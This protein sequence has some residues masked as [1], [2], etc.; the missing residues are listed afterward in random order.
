MLSPI[1]TESSEWV[2]IELRAVRMISGLG[3]T[4]K[5]GFTPEALEIRAASAPVA[6]MVPASLGP[7]TSGVV[8]TERA[9]AATR[10]IARAILSNE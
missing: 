3:L 1:I 5:Y 6:G 8:E 10:R 2:S 9:P 4:T 7:A